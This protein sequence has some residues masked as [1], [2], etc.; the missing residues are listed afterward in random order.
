MATIIFHGGLVL[1]FFVLMA[2]TAP[3]PPL[4]KY[5]VEINLGF[6]TEG[7]GEAQSDVDP[8][9]EGSQTE[10]ESKPEENQLP[11][12]KEEAKESQPDKAVVTDDNNPVSVKS[13]E[14]TDIKEEVKTEPKKEIKPSET[15]KPE[16][17]KEAIFTPTETTDKTT[18]QKKGENKSE[19]NDL[20]ATGNKGQPDG[21]LD[22]NAQYSGLKGGGAGGS[23]TGLDLDGWDW[24]RVPKPVLPGNERGEMLYE[25]KVDEDGELINIKPIKILSAEADRICR[26]E[27][28]KLTFTAKGTPKAATGKI[29]FVIKAD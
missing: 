24:D 1:L 23:G 29:K 5:G 25:I 11:E 9:N 14:K 18:T 27:I 17:K 28:A 16:V 22:P 6:Q 8:G 12:V 7:T 20:N 19:G 13:E 26:A 21:T 2:W 4:P 10:T 15:K 3:D